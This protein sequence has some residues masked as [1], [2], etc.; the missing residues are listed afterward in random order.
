M[1][2]F[3]VVKDGYP[4]IIIFVIIA[5][6]VA[7]VSNPVYAVIPGV[8]AIYLAYFFRNPHRDITPDDSLLYSPADG[9]VMAVEDFYDDEYLDEPAIKVT[10]FLSVF[11]VHVNR[12]PMRGQIKYQRYTC[13]GFV[14]AYKKS[15]SFENER[16]AIGLENE[17]NRILVIQIAGLLA[18][19]IVSWTTLGHNLEQGQCY[20]MIKFGSSTELVMPKSVEV[21]VKKG[22]TVKGGISVI[23]RFKDK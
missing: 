3:A 21:L 11:N 9:R 16:H 17:K 10:I 1:K 23:G 8:L 13:G 4:H 5:F 18:R 20:G 22:D 19:R 12:S 7:Y 6:I 15:A 14:P 2:R